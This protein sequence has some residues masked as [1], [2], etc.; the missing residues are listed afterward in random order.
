[1]EFLLASFHQIFNLK[2]TIS[3]HTKDFS[4]EKKYP[5]LPD[6]EEIKL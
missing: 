1:M 2:N 4:S 3:T 5:N 6:F